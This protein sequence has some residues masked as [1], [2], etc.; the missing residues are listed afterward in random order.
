MVIIKE[1]YNNEKKEKQIII[2]RWII[3]A[4]KTND[5]KSQHHS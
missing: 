2:V 1:I 5:V 3:D 4:K